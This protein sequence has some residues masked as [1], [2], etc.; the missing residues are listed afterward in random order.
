[1]LNLNHFQLRFNFRLHLK[2][3]GR[4]FL[5]YF[6]LPG[7]IKNLR[8]YNQKCCPRKSLVNES[9]PD[10]LA[11]IVF[12][13]NIQRV[14]KFHILVDEKITLFNKIRFFCCIFNLFV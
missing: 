4:I 3:F 12:V 10:K 7:L 13:S 11:R 5:L 2:A 6:F 9:P 1:L 14:V 8:K